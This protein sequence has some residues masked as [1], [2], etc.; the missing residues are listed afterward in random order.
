M[1]GN[2]FYRPRRNDV[3]NPNEDIYLFSTTGQ[4]KGMVQMVEIPKVG[5]QQAQRYV[6]LH[7]DD[8]D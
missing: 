1:G 5:L 3:N 7:L 4:P 6:L 8:I 2:N